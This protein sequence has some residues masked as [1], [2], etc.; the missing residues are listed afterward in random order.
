MTHPGLEED[1]RVIAVANAPTMLRS[2]LDG[3]EAAL[4]PTPAGLIT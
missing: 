4:L 3:V 1:G 2:Y